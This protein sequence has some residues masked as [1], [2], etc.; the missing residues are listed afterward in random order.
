MWA[1]ITAGLKTTAAALGII[2][3]RQELNNSPE[4][5][6]NVVAKLTEEQIAKNRDT[7]NRAAAGDK[8][9]LDDLRKIAG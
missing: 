6:N 9:A 2:E 7:I 4:I 3:K 1:A 5:V 8:K